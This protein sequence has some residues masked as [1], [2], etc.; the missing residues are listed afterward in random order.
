MDKME[1]LEHQGEPALYINTS[2]VKMSKQKDKCLFRSAGGVGGKWLKALPCCL[3]GFW[4]DSIG[5][6][7]SKILLLLMNKALG[8]KKCSDSVTHALRSRNQ[9]TFTPETCSP[10][11]SFF[12]LIVIHFI[13]SHFPFYFLSL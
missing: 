7:L 6:R 8:L 10:L 9:S 12:L 4:K 11:P 5:L 3:L 13:P 1:R 2:G